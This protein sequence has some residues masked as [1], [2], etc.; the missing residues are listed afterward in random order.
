MTETT[1][2]RNFVLARSP[3]ELRVHVSGD[4][5]ESDVRTP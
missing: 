5:R 1:H 3:F 2:R 4:I